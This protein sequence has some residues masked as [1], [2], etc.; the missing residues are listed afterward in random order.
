MTSRR[1]AKP[2]KFAEAKSQE[3]AYLVAV[4]SRSGPEALMPV[5]YSLRELARLVRT[6]GGTVS[7]RTSQRRVHPHPALILD[8]ARLRKLGHLEKN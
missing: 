3:R 7:G 1:K 2:R 4:E 6:A 5:D 8:G